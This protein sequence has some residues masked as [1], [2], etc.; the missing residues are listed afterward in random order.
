GQYFVDVK[1]RRVTMLDRGQA[2]IIDEK[3][4]AM[5]DGFIGASLVN[6]VRKLA[7]YLSKIG[8]QLD[9]NQRAKLKAYLKASQ[10]QHR[11]LQVLSWIEAQKL[12][13]HR[14]RR[15]QSTC[16]FS[17]FECATGSVGGLS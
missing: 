1:T 3:I 14:S 16:A 11:P 4:Q 8:V 13:R 15:L 7:S 5:R 6:N 2:R 17:A 12:A 9:P 10:T